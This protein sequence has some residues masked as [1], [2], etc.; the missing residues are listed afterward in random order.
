LPPAGFTK[1]VQGGDSYETPA[2]YSSQRRRKAYEGAEIL[3]PV[4]DVVWNI[5]KERG[6]ARSF[7]LKL[8]IR[9]P[10]T[11]WS[12]N[13]QTANKRKRNRI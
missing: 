8:T 10:L 5:Y 9:L 3:E 7:A 12:A 11:F 4:I 6:D 2:T 13:E 1:Q